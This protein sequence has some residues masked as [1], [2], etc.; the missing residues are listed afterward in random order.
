MS[1]LYFV[2]GGLELTKAIEEANGFDFSKGWKK[3]KGKWVAFDMQ[4]GMLCAGKDADQALE[5]ARKLAACRREQSSSPT[6]RTP[7][8]Y[9][10]HGT[11]RSV[12]L[13]FRCRQN[14]ERDDGSGTWKEASTRA[15]RPG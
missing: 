10:L 15:L 11:G 13:L 14:R 9:I 5:K 2:S 7:R 3:Y 1:E 4:E 8:A 6:N 12:L